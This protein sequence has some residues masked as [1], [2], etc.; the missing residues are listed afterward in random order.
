MSAATPALKA[1]I[2][3]GYVVDHEKDRKSIRSHDKMRCLQ[4]EWHAHSR[5]TVLH[6]CAR[7]QFACLEGK[8]HVGRSAQC[9]ACERR[10]FHV[11]AAIRLTEQ[12]HQPPPRHAALQRES[13]GQWWEVESMIRCETASGGALHGT[14]RCADSLNDS[15]SCTTSACRLTWASPGPI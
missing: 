11:F 8:P 13:F 7:G 12:S 6:D 2:T 1:N 4:Y 9:F 3:V 10:A 14:R 15:E 5:R